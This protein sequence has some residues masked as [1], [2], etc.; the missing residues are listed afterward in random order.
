MNE[1][2]LIFFPSQGRAYKL[3]KPE[4]IS[5]IEYILYMKMNLQTLLSVLRYRPPPPPSS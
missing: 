1:I 2:F 4:E 5:T 3:M